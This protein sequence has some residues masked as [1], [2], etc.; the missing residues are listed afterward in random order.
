MVVE[1][2]DVTQGRGA[3]VEDQKR[4]RA[5]YAEERRQGGNGY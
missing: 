3:V 2:E 4:K 1:G 5:E